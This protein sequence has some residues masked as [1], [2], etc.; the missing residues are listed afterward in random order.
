MADSPL[1][2]PGT[3]SICMETQCPALLASPSS[4]LCEVLCDIFTGYLPG[5]MHKLW[6][7]RLCFKL[8]VPNKTPHTNVTQCKQSFKK[9]R[10][11]ASRNATGRGESPSLNGDEGLLYH[12]FAYCSPIPKI[13]SPLGILMYVKHPVCTL[14]VFPSRKWLFLF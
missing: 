5:T 3:P 13:F 4:A 10:N 7:A 6:G 8:P 12:F 1:S 2:V 14:L 11:N 9:N